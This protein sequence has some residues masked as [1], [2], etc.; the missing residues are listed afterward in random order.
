MNLRVDKS[1]VEFK[2]FSAFYQNE[3]Q[4]QL[5]QDNNIDSPVN[6]AFN[7]WVR[8][9]L[10]IKTLEDIRKEN[11]LEYQRI[12]FLCEH[13]LIFNLM[14]HNRLDLL[15]LLFEKF[16]AENK[17]PPGH[18]ERISQKTPST[19][20][21]STTTEANIA[22]TAQIEALFQHV[23]ALKKEQPKF[24]RWLLLR[25][26]LQQLED[27]HQIERAR[28]RYNAYQAMD[29][30]LVDFINQES[31]DP[32]IHAAFETF[33]QDRHA[34]RHELE[35]AF[36]RVYANP[37]E[38]I[39]DVELINDIYKDFLQQALDLSNEYGLKTKEISQGLTSIKEQVDKDIEKADEHFE[40]LKAVA[41][42]QIDTIKKEA[43]LE[44]KERIGTLRDFV[45]GARRTLQSTL[46]EEQTTAFDECFWQLERLY[47]AIDKADSKEAIQA[48]LST[49]GERLS[50]F[51][52][53]AEAIPEMQATL[54]RL[55]EITGS[56]FE[57]ANKTVNIPFAI[58]VYASS[59]DV[60]IVTATP[61]QAKPPQRLLNDTY[62]PPHN[63]GDSQLVREEASEKAVN[64]TPIKPKKT[65]EAANNAT[66]LQQQQMREGLQAVREEE[67][68]VDTQELSP[69]AEEDH[70][71]AEDLLKKVTLLFDKEKQQADPAWLE[72]N[73]AITQ[74]GA[75]IQNLQHTFETTKQLSPS[76]L[77]ALQEAIENLSEEQPDMKSLGAIQESLEEL[78]DYLEE[79][80]SGIAL[81]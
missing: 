13:N 53:V 60:P 48:L 36:E 15:R 55:Q 25:E 9:Q 81:H 46:T 75:H 42:A 50:N 6:S 44:Q 52:E 63:P 71:D 26:N 21:T 29:Q 38:N 73:E 27:A 74:I 18:R 20:T 57:L 59:P 28:I 54:A 67:Q 17:K 32:D 65:T 78:S 14:F 2:E 76:T 45:L 7:E 80:S 47:Q 41:K 4:K 61:I 39:A 35:Q 68:V 49:C 34:Q 40:G 31:N 77:I 72:E 1:E 24:E 5:F 33:R 22:T 70:E 56:F 16:E 23:E 10:G 3:L 64:S 43:L 30:L 79:P 19:L 62:E 37:R 69:I 11:L 8:G 58:P 66:S 12:V 51:I